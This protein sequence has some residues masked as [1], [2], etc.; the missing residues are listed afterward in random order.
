MGAFQFD[1]YL[2][3]FI[4]LLS[5]K[6][7]ASSEDLGMNKNKDDNIINGNND[8]IN[9]NNDKDIN[10]NNRNNNNNIHSNNNLNKTLK[11]ERAGKSKPIM[12]D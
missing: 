12:N 11:N 9:N 6:I 10:N 3:F 8:N 1:F 5:T 7:F 4:F 2:P